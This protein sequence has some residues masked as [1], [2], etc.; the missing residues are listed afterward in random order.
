MTVVFVKSCI[1]AAFSVVIPVTRRSV[2]PLIGDVAS[3]LLR[4]SFVD[5]DEWKD[6]CYQHDSLACVVVLVQTGTYSM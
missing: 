1:D 3:S 2:P 5:P 6:R 4:P